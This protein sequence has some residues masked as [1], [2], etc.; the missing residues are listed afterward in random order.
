MYLILAIFLKLV[1]PI[2][3]FLS[4]LFFVKLLIN[5]RQH[6]LITT[7]YNPKHKCPF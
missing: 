1:S 6:I 2:S 7:E 3:V 4:S 5:M